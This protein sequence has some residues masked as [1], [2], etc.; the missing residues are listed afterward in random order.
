[1]LH[2]IPL[3]SLGQLRVAP[4]KQLVGARMCDKPSATFEVFWVPPSPTTDRVGEVKVLKFSV[5]AGHAAAVSLC[6]AIDCWIHGIPS[7]STF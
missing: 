3:S 2:I 1:M 4:I 5:P 6:D 7:G